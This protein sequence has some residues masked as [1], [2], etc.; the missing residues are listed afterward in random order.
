MKRN[1]SLHSILD[2]IKK[3]CNTYNSTNSCRWVIPSLTN[4]TPFIFSSLHAFINNSS[5][6][7]FPVYS[8]ILTIWCPSKEW[9]TYLVWLVRLVRIL[10]MVYTP[11]SRY[12]NNVL[13]LI[14]SLQKTIHFTSVCRCYYW[15][16]PLN[17]ILIAQSTS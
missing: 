6:M 12:L 2:N 14:Y 4:S 7:I 16:N 10:I 17:L 5:T 9:G 8:F 13:D 1:N 3:H 11:I 15:R